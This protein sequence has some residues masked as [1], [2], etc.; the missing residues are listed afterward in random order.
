LRRSSSVSTVFGVNCAMGE[1]N[2]TVAGI[3]FCGAA[4]RTIRAS[5]PNLS[6]PVTVPGRKMY[7]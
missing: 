2:D 1:M 6:F 7:M 3:G 4:S 5:E